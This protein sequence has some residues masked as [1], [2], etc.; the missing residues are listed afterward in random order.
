MSDLRDELA[1]VLSNHMGDAKAPADPHSWRCYDKDRYPGDCGC[2]ASSL[3]EDLLPII[4]RETGKAR[5]AWTAEH[6]RA[7]LQ[8]VTEIDCGLRL[9]DMEV[10]RAQFSVARHTIATLRGLLQPLEQLIQRRP[11]KP[12][13]GES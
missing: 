1:E 3:V 13:G 8:L 9:A 7:A 10:R 5:R 4:E 6:H 12:S 2:R 11:I